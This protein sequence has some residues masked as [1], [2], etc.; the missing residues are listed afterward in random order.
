MGARRIV[1]PLDGSEAGEGS[2]SG[3][4]DSIPGDSALEGWP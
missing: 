1:T 2:C 4:G 3:D